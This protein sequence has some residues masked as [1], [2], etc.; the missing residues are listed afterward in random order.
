MDYEL[1]TLHMQQATQYS[2]SPLQPEEIINSRHLQIN[3]ATLTS[4]L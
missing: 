1:L 3:L 4:A 2:K